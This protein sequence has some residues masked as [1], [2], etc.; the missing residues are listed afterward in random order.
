MDRLCTR[1]RGIVAVMVAIALLALIAMVGFALDS[2]HLMLNKS[3]LQNTVDAVAL[4]AAKGLD[5]S[6]S[7]TRATTAGRAVFDANATNQPE[8]ARAI[9]G[10]DLIF[11]YSNTLSPWAPGSVPANYV[12]V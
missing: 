11:T 4:S 12:R 10:A 3:R 8:L 1:E 2:G 7:G 9:R 6:G 5:K